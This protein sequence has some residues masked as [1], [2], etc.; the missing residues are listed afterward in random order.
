[1][2]VGLPPQDPLRP[3]FPPLSEKPAPFDLDALERIAEVPAKRFRWRH[4][5][6]QRRQARTYEGPTVTTAR[7]SVAMLALI[8]EPE[9]C[10][11]LRDALAAGGARYLIP[12]RLT[13]RN[14][15]SMQDEAAWREVV[16]DVTRAWRPF[17]VRLSG[18]AIIERRALCLQPVGDSVRDLQEAL[19][20]ALATA[21]FVPR[22]GDVSAP[23]VLLAGTFTDLSR[24]ELHQLAGAVQDRVHFP[25]DFPATTLYAIAEASGDDDLP[26][27]AFPLAG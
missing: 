15:L 23:M 2:L 27:G 19:G 18:P 25:M 12:P 8:P 21:G 4:R 1:M 3:E 7:A 16:G 11:A 24:T 9:Q 22:V 14:G 26:I 13:L 17:T 6:R 10:T 5:G 20:Y